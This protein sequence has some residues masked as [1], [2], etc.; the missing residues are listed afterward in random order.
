MKKDVMNEGILKKLREGYVMEL[1]KPEIDVFER[2][3]IISQVLQENG[4]SIREMGRQYN[5][6]KSTIEDW[7]LFT[8]IS[9]EEYDKLLADGVTPTEIYRELRNHKKRK[10]PKRKAQSTI[11]SLDIYLR[12][13]IR[14][15]DGYVSYDITNDTLELLN[16]LKDQVSLMAKDVKAQLGGIHK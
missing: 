4:W 9:E 11:S 8:K 16:E 7:L 14:E 2:A 13:I 3:A 1:R 12:E 15:L 6:P 5:I 10:I